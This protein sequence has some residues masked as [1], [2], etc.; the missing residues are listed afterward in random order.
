VL[1]ACVLYPACLRD[2][3][4]RLS[5]AGLYRA[6]WSELIHDEWTRSLLKTRPDLRGKLDRTVQLMNAAVPD[7]LVT[8]YELIIDSLELPDP[9]DRHVLAAA[10]RVGAD[11]IVTFNQK[12]FP[13]AVL[14]KYGIY[15]EHP[16][17]FVH[18]MVTLETGKVLTAVRE[19]RR[20]LKNPEVSV[21]EFLDRLTGTGLVQTAIALQ[22]FENL[23]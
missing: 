23:I 22:D 6:K 4:L 15:S 2:L 7:C 14:E 20:S 19:Q 12:D 16:D 9:D 21:G 13:D 11:S 5:V 17:D 10:I 3:L 1:D 8:G 18:N